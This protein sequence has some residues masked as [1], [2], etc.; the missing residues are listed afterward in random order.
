M[1]RVPPKC[2]PKTLSLKPKYSVSDVCSVPWTH[3]LLEPFWNTGCGDPFRCWH[4]ALYPGTM[5]LQEKSILHLASSHR[6]PHVPLFISI[7]YSGHVFN[8]LHPPPGPVCV[9]ACVCVYMSVCVCCRYCYSPW[10]W[11][12]EHSNSLEF[13]VLCTSVPQAVV[14]K[15]SELQ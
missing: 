8:R 13:I 4:I 10:N 14:L 2:K 15:K 12:R 3:I 11:I 1:K 7:H 9:R 5:P 6:R